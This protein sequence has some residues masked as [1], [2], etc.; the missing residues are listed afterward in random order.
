MCKHLLKIQ[1]LILA[2]LIF[3]GGIFYT[4]SATARVCFLPD[5]TDC[6]EGDVEVQITCATY[7]GYETEAA[8]LEARTNKTAQTC[9]LNS[10]CY[11]PKCAYDS[12]R[13]GTLEDN[14]TLAANVF[15]ASTLNVILQRHTQQ[16]EADWRIHNLVALG[17]AY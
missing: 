14:A 13:N 9:T 4:S 3:G 5:S 12:E 6:G 7:G 15:Y 2:L 16:A 10:G 8:C 17:N 11:Y 1:R